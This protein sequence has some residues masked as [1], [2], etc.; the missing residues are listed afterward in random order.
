M[1]PYSEVLKGLL[2]SMH[3][4][5][6][7]ASL[8]SSAVAWA[9]WK[10]GIPFE[11][12]AMIQAPVLAFIV[13]ESYADGKA[14]ENTST[15]NVGSAGSVDNRTAGSGDTG[16]TGAAGYDGQTGGATIGYSLKQPVTVTADRSTVDEPG[17]V[18]A[19][20]YAG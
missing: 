17:E 4:R 3:S 11:V 10:Y 14:R 12:Q 9:G 18:I 6:F 20:D 1:K 7:L 5:R 13:G 19:N 15:V 2:F 16:T 8:V